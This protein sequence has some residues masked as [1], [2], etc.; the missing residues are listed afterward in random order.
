MIVQLERIGQRE[1]DATRDRTRRS[2]QHDVQRGVRRRRGRR[3]P[4]DARARRG[5]DALRAAGEVKPLLLED[6]D[7]AREVN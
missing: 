2:V 6:I 3:A 1:N 5:H 7:L 4:R